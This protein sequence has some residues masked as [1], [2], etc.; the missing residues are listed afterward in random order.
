MDLD[1]YCKLRY[2][3]S[4]K[5]KSSLHLAYILRLMLTSIIV[6]FILPVHFILML[7][8]RFNAFFSPQNLNLY[9][10]LYTFSKKNYSD[11]SILLSFYFI[12]GGSKKWGHTNT[13]NVYT[14]RVP[15]VIIPFK[16]KMEITLCKCQLGKMLST[17][18]W[19]SFQ[20][21]QNVDFCRIYLIN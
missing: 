11:W 21:F 19:S 6:P 7:D 3:Y 4:F 15:Y 20:K 5:V 16:I 8:L 18:F 1:E 12:R 9:A 17:Y 2:R 10:A 14:V 13:G